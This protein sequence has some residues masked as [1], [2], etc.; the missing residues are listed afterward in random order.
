MYLL[1]AYRKGRASVFDVSGCKSTLPPFLPFVV[2][3]FNEVRRLV[4]MSTPIV[5][6]NVTLVTYLITLIMACNKVI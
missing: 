6:G 2:L 4:Y 1:S 3:S 5:M